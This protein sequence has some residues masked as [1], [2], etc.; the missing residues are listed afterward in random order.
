MHFKEKF[1]YHIWDA[2]HIVDKLKT[3]SGKEIKIMFQGR[4]NTDAG[5]DFKDAIIEIDGDVKRGDVEIHLKSYDWT[6]HN[7]NEDSNFNTVTLHVVYEHNG[8]YTH[9]ISESGEKIEILEIKDKL[10]KDISKL[11]K[12]YAE[13]PFKGK[14]RSCKLFKN[15]DIVSMEKM[16]LKFG[17]ERFEKKIKRFTAEHYFADF[18]QLLLQGLFEALGYSKNKYQMLQ[19]ALR[20]P[21]SKLKEFYRNGITHDELIAVWLCSTDLIN[22]LP[23]TFPTELKTKWQQ[24]YLKQDFQK[25]PI[26]AGWKLFRIRPVNHPAIRLLQV[27]ELIY[28]SLD[29]S[30]F[31]AILRL[32]S[33]NADKFN[34]KDFRK[35]L[36]AFF[37]S[38]FEFLP[39]RYTL[40]K[41]RIDTILVNIIL[42]HVVIYARE[43]EYIELEKA[44]MQVYLKYPALP[45][46]FITQYMENFMDDIQK[47]ISKKKAI[48]Q[49][50]LLKLYYDNCRHHACEVCER[51]TG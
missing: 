7:H 42:P 33:F 39:E 38:S 51:E 15:T 46:N 23:S 28:K 14:E 41:T 18:D 19:L 35:N 22:H 25:E 8:Q 40:G 47:K 50:G 12:Q 34:L 9:T 2:Q 20:F 27:S 43:K 5:A 26:D 45:S 49:Q 17:L 21:F 6:S 30:L 3:I 36:Y 10:N 48:Y 16:L 4:W 32:F 44:I 11:L 37:Q 29:T 13:K 31:N 1:L 24:I